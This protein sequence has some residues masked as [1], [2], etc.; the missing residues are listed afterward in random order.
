MAMKGRVFS[1][2]RPSGKLHIGNWLGALQNWV[3][4]QEDYD[5]FYFVAD[6]HALTTL[7]GTDA[8]DEINMDSIAGYQVATSLGNA[9]DRFA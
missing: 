9:D 2:M 3:S 8:V 4:L 5:C 6:V 1:G 7:S